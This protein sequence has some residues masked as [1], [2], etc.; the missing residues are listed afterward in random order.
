[1]TPP[2]PG[3]SPTLQPGQI[4]YEFGIPIPGQILPMESWAKTAIRRVPDQCPIDWATVFGRSARLCLD[5]GCGNGRFTLASAIDRP[6]WNHVAIDSLPAVIRYA[7]RRANQRGLWHTRFLAVDGWRL[8]DDCS[9]DH[10]WDEIHIYHPQPYAD[11]KKANLR[12]LTPEFLLRMHQRL[13]PDGRVFIQTDRKAYWDYIQA[14]MKEVFVWSPIDGDW[15]D[16]PRY[17]SRR[18]ILA[19]K[20]GLRIFRGI[21]H[22]RGDRTAEELDRCIAELPQPRFK[23]N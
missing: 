4:E 16:G 7:T 15:P 9:S 5:V 14:T 11:T 2:D 3:P 23:V 19:R 12:M 8:L 6:D 22:R 21:A 20:Q 10:S 13:Q 1:M 17:R 18:E